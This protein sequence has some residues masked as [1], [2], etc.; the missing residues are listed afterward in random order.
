VRPRCTAEGLSNNALGIVPQARG[1][2][3]RAILARLLGPD[4]FA[5]RFHGALLC[6]LLCASTP[7]RAQEPLL[8]RARIAPGKTAAA[9]QLEGRGR[10]KDSG[11]DGAL[12]AVLAADGR[13]YFDFDASLPERTAF[14]GATTWMRDHMGLERRLEL[15]DA[16]R[17]K[18]FAWV[19]SG[20]WSTAPE[21][22]LRTL[23][24][25]ADEPPRLELA[26]RSTPLTMVLALDATTLLPSELGYVD[27]S[28][29]VSWK[30]SDYREVAGRRLAHRWVFDEGA[31][32]DEF[33]IEEWKS[34][35]SDAAVFHAEFAAPEDV[36][37]QA[38]I[39]PELEVVRVASGHLLVEPWIEG[40]SVG[41]FIFDT[42]AGAMTIDPAIADELG[43]PELGEVVAVGVGGRTTASFRR[44]TRFELGPLV[45]EDPVY[46]EL[47]LAF[48]EPQFGHKVA[49][50]VGFDVLARCV[51][52]IETRTPYVA[53]HDPARFQLAGASWQDLTIA[54]NTPSVRARFEGDHEGLFRIDTGANGT[55]SFHAPAVRAFALLDGRTVTSGSSGGVG[56]S[57]ETKDGRLAWFELA[58]HRFEKRQV[59]FSLAERG[60]FTDQYTV[61]NIGQEFLAPFRMV[62]DYPG[63]RIAFVP[64]AK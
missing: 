47:D 62:L 12:R 37:F 17:A 33:E 22:A 19:L 23:E 36:S 51:A 53:L 11:V 18:L 9:P 13:F 20:Y 46:V 48:L 1:I 21:L 32:L 59:Q 3:L 61:G 63:D 41:L 54:E 40:E 16:D 7:N 30:F 38:E 60:A 4:G 31:G 42:G 14:D 27:D 35:P 56:G 64:L 29:P 57:A 2:G 43:M 15:E 24:S 25:R 39:E 49:G 6:G 10:A 28:G 55:V 8:E 58:G 34:M 5:R 45:L 50:I 52:E 26:L 44:G